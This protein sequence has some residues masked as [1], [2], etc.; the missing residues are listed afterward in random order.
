MKEYTVTQ[1]HKEMNHLMKD[2]HVTVVGEISGFN[3]SNDKFVW[4]TLK[5]DKSAMSNF[6]MKFQLKVPLEDGMEIRVTGSPGIFPRSGKYVFKPRTVELMGE[7]ALQRA[8]EITK[9][10]LEEEG[11][12]DPDRKREF[13]RFPER[14]GLITSPDA[15]AYTDFIRILNNRWGGVE[16]R[17]F[18]VNVQGNNAINSIQ[19]A[20]HLINSFHED[21]DAVVLTRGGGSME[22][23]QAFNSEEVARAV[24][25]SQVPVICGVGH[26]RDTSLADYVADLRAATPTHAAELLVPD[27]E[28]VSA[29][30]RGLISSQSH[31]LEQQVSILTQAVDRQ[32]FEL[33]HIMRDHV[34]FLKDQVAR[35]MSAA[36]MVSIDIQKKKDQISHQK[37]LVQTYA[38]TLV[39]M[40]RQ[41]LEQQERLINSLSP[42]AVLKR[43][44]SMTTAEDGSII[45]DPSQVKKGQALKTEVEHGI[46]H[47]NVT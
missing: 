24:F 32:M 2:I 26:E 22:D 11:L 38:A 17:F 35:F 14:I 43:G 44:Y 37:Q 8:F 40:S 3:I 29:E 18:P 28:E 1:F 23:L 42:K 12:F 20:F 16:V 31:R 5:D 9:A 25:G 34:T 33:G 27:K 15:A 10:K 39:S 19:D 30:I 45:K 6:M 4:F 36:H 47:S 46:I 21:L 41:R 7:G 13:P